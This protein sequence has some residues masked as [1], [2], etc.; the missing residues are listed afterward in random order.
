MYRLGRHVGVQQG[1]TQAR[2]GFTVR[3]H[4]GLYFGQQLGVL[5]FRFR[6]DSGGDVVDAGYAGLI[7]MAPRRNLWVDSDLF[8]VFML[9]KISI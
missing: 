6:L 5:V 3:L 2:L 8:S 9:L 4:D 1:S 7:F